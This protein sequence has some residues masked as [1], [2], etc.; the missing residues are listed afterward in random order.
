MTWVPCVR[1][2]MTIMWSSCVEDETESGSVYYRQVLEYVGK[3]AELYPTEAFQL[4]VS[5]VII[6]DSGHTSLILLAWHFVHRCQK[7]RNMLRCIWVWSTSSREKEMV[8][9]VVN[10][11]Y[12]YIFQS[13]LPRACPAVVSRP[14]VWEA[15]CCTQGPT[16]MLQAIGRLSEQFYI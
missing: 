9:A 1:S 13:S 4:T 10:A 2:H 5:A 14:W 11:L 3:V 8:Y 7:W 15:P 6:I 12:V 16:S